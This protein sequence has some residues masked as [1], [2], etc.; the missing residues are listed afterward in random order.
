MGYLSNFDV[1][2]DVKDSQGHSRETEG[3][4]IQIEGIQA[5]DVYYAF[6]E[7]GSL[8]G[9]PAPC[10]IRYCKPQII[11]YATGVY[12]RWTVAGWDPL[13]SSSPNFNIPGWS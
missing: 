10:Y 3:F 2:N 1:P 8:N 9:P 12:V 6:G 13:C 7:A 4:E 11:Q 5:A